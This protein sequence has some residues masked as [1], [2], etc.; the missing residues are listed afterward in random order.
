[1]GELDEGGTG[2]CRSRRS[3]EEQVDGFGTLAVFSHLGTERDG[4]A[5]IAVVEGGESRKRG[6]VFFFVAE[7]FVKLCVQAMHRRVVGRQ[8][9]RLLDGVD[10]IARTVARQQRLSQ[11]ELE[12]Q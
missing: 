1:M 5:D 11:S 8:R 2:F 6:E 4:G 12:G 10:G 9:Q 3:V 7:A